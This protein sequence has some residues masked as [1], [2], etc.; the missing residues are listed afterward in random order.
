MVLSA[1]LRISWAVAIGEALLQLMDVRT[2]VR[3]HDGIKAGY[4]KHART[5]CPVESRRLLS[6]RRPGTRKKARNHAGLLEP[7]GELEPPTC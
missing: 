6:N 4:T 1:R 7:T 2:L 3:N 5:G